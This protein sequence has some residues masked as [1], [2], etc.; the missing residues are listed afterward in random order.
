MTVPYLEIHQ[1]DV[2]QGA[3]QVF[4][5]LDLRLFY[6]QQTAILGPNGAGKSTL[7]KLLTRELYPRVADD[8]YV[9]ID[10][11]E[12]VVIWELRQKIGLVSQDLQSGYDGH[13]RAIDVVLSGLFGSVGIHMHQ[14]PTEA[15]R[16]AAA[17]AL[18]QVGLS[19]SADAYYAHLSTGQQRRLLLARALIHR[20]K[21]LILDEPT[22]GLD[23]Q[24]SFAL[25]RIMRELAQQ[26]VSLLLVTHHLGE[27]IPEISRLILLS[28]GKLVADGDKSTILTAEHLSALYKTPLALTLADGYYQARPSAT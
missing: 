2:F 11:S 18:E 9:K 14:T 15:Q 7:I 19:Q 25:L 12:R 22:N 26:G 4:T 21:V 17:A 8:S 20:P 5:K 28:D 27:I 23:L 24:G 6:G 13:I 1:A 16:Q 3:R 10:G